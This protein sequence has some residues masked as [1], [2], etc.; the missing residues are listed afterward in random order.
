[1]MDVACNLIGCVAVQCRIYLKE[2]GGLY[3]SCDFATRVIVIVS[4]FVEASRVD[5]FVGI[6]ELEGYGGC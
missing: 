4:P 2:R 5:H 1:M 3:H 6:H